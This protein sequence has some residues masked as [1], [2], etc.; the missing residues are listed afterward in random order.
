[1]A[2]R[3]KNMPRTARCQA[4]V[5]GRHCVGDASGPVHQHGAQGVA[6][7]LAGEVHE[8][9]GDVLPVG[10][11]FSSRYSRM[12]ARASTVSSARLAAFS[13]S[14]T[15]PG[16]AAFR[17]RSA[18][19]ASFSLTFDAQ[20]DSSPLHW[21]YAAVPAAA[22]T[23]FAAGAKSRQIEAAVARLRSARAKLA[24]AEQTLYNQLLGATLSADSARQALEVAESALGAAQ[25][26]FDIVSSRYDVG[27]ASVLER[28]DA[29]VALTRAQAEVVT[30]RYNL[31]DTQ[32]LV[33]R[34]LGD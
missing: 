2:S 31:L 3:E 22:Q 13:A 26:N 33:S 20:G 19:A 24:A 27:K 30:A 10:R 28:T 8:F 11:D 34:L 18:S 7:G 9:F 32:I 16:V 1:M 4:E 6:G 21:N 17:M 15:S 14:A 25:E 29:Q 5:L 23:L 12:P